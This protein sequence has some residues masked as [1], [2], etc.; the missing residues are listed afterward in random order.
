MAITRWSYRNPWQELDTLSNRL[1][2]AFDSTLPDSANGGT[3]NP[4]V[5]IEE[6]PEALYLTAELPGVREEDVELEV[7]N[8]I[9]TLRGEKAETRNEKVDR[10]HLYE[11]R[12][13]SFHRSFTL[14]RT[15]VADEIQAEYA[16]GVL[17]V[18]LPKAPEAKSRK[19]EIGR[20]IP[21]GS[22]SRTEVGATAASEA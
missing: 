22:T 20:S 21:E 13:G 2:A 17:H 5:N 18:T 19:I 10:F 11:R 15:V 8:N 14:P 3:W 7:E 9:L 16:D 6:T 4:S 12:S 1:Q